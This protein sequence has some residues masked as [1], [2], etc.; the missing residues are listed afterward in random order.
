MAYTSLAQAASEADVDEFVAEMTD[1]Y[2]P[3]PAP[4]TILVEVAR[5][6]LLARRAGITDI[7]AAGTRIRFAPVHLPESRTM[8]LSRLYPGS[9]Y[10]AASGTVLVPAPKGQGLGAKPLVDH[11]LLSWVREAV[12]TVM[13]P[14][15]P[16]GAAPA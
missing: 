4:V 10:K 3:L 7:V 6:R 2:G 15:S 13:L 8:R 14:S 12:E 1:R 16:D 11:D 9:L 5:L